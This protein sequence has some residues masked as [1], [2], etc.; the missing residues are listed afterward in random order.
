MKNRREIDLK[1]EREECEPVEK[2]RR[3]KNHA[4]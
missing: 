4:I 1:R 3:R 2:K